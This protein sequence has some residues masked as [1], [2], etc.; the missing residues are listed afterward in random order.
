M[1]RGIDLE[2]NRGRKMEKGKK[3]GDS[4]RVKEGGS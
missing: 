3:R 2:R 4:D 1:D